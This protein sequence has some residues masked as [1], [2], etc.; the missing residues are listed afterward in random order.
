MKQIKP[1]LLAAAL[2]S[3]VFA[4]APTHAANEHAGHEHHVDHSK[5]MQQPAE[6]PSSVKVKLLDSRM[7][8]Q[9]GVLR[10]LKS[11]VVGDKLAVISFAYT[12]CTTVC[13]ALTTL[14]AKLQAE[15]L[16]SGPSDVQLV[17]ITLDP[18]RDTPARLRAFGKQYGVKPGWVWLTGQTGHVNEVLKGLGAYTPRFEDH[19]PL[20]LVG[21]PVSGN[22]TRFVGFTD[23]KELLEKVRQLK[24]ART[25]GK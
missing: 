5:H 12:S 20:V 1:S 10:K 18:A 9:D 14:M 4:V 23:P 8:D 22:W 2:A 7:V 19:P 6:K 16:E 25:A 24:A 11:D 21:D 17:T 13:P 15:L 3:L